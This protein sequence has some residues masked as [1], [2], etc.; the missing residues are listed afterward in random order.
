MAAPASMTKRPPGSLA[1]RFWSIARSSGPAGDDT[2]NPDPRAIVRHVLRILDA[3]SAG[4]VGDGVS[5]STISFLALLRQQ[6]A[7]GDL[8]YASP[9]QARGEALDERSLVF[10]VG[11]LMFEELT[12]RHPFGAVDSP[13]RFARI[14]KCEL[15]SGVQYFP[16]VPGQLRT[17]LMRAMGPFPEERY[18]S[19]RELR[20]H[21]DRF[22]EGRP[23]ETPAPPQRRGPLKGLPPTP[24][25][26]AFSNVE[27]SIPTMIVRKA[28][29]VAP[30]LQSQSQSSNRVPTPTPT[31][32]SGQISPRTIAANSVWDRAAASETSKVPPLRRT[33]RK[34]RAIV[35][36]VGWV[37]LGAAV[38]V[39][40]MQLL[41]GSHRSGVVTASNTVAAAVS[42]VSTPLD[43]AA[44]AKPAPA[45][46]V[47][48]SDAIFEP[49]LAGHN[50][51]TKA[52]ECFSPERLS[53]T[54]SFGAGLL[55]GKGDTRSRR[56]FLA[57]DEPLAPEERR[58]IA[59]NLVGASAGGKADRSLVAEYRVRLHPDGSDDVKTLSAK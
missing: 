47:P 19:L 11:V 25:D 59:K 51:A 41:S 22:V 32:V 21:L 8:S 42:P 3:L 54:L 14:Q 36:R 33:K 24:A 20:A 44:A 38:S 12:G 15:G 2:T 40:A 9:E 55:F 48:A 56:V 30:I 13:R 39:G 18:R 17:V 58:C 4:E 26:L 6:E 35:E 57:S 31:S 23:D 29:V 49:D 28:P 5:Q 1:E 37:L 53:K 34:Q 16:Q 46:A 10:S 7:A 50:A 43:V 52:R 45:V 27:D